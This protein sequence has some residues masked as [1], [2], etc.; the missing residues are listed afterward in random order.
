MD[1]NSFLFF[2]FGQMALYSLLF[3]VVLVAI[4]RLYSA[5]CSDYWRRRAAKEVTFELRAP[6]GKIRRCIREF[7]EQEGTATAEQL[8]RD[9]ASE[10]SQIDLVIE[11]YDP[12][13]AR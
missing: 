7:A 4:I 9:V 6:A 8:R 3:F 2:L 12:T 1:V 10:L 13:N 11:R 5:K